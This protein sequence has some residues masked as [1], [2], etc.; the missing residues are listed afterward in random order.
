MTL[1]ANSLI[2]ESRIRAQQDYTRA[3]SLDRAAVT[4]AIVIIQTYGDQLNFHPHDRGK[5]TN[6]SS[7]ESD[8]F[9]NW[10][11][12]NPIFAINDRGSVVS[13]TPARLHDQ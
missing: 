5:L 3:Q 7:Y 10:T 13:A 2:P 12:L 6:I 4:G 9:V 8:D 1:S 11:P